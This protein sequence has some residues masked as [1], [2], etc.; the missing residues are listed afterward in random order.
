[1]EHTEK[2]M[3][4]PVGSIRPN[5]Y[6]P[7]TVFEEDRALFIDM[8]FFF[9]DLMT[10]RKRMRYSKII[11]LFFITKFGYDLQMIPYNNFYT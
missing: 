1:M 3:E 11:T 7:R 6:Q 2:L 9:I 5:P 10:M 8:S 4:L